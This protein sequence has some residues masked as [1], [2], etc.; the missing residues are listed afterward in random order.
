VASTVGLK[1]LKSGFSPLPCEVTRA[2]GSLHPENV[3][4]CR[5]GQIEISSLGHLLK[6]GNLN[7]G[8][9][10]IFGFSI[11][12]AQHGSISGG[13]DLVQSSGHLLPYIIN[14]LKI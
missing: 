7:P 13:W 1:R 12:P 10:G 8:G 5:A 3:E 2:T 6:C 9:G 14:S 4:S 11:C